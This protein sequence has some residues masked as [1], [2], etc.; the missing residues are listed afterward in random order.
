MPLS[1]EPLLIVGTG[2]LACFFAARLSQAGT[3]V[4]MLGSWPEGLA[5]LKERGVRVIQRDGGET[6]YPVEVYSVSDS[7]P[8][9]DRALVLVKSWQTERAAEQLQ[10]CLGPHGYALTLQN[11][12]GNYEI[13]ATGLG[14]KRTLAGVTT[15]GASLIAPGQVLP[16]GDGP[17]SI[18]Q[19]RGVDKFASIFAQAGFIVEV[20]PDV[21]ALLWRKLV[22][23]A[24]INP[25]T[26]ILGVQNGK[27]SESDDLRILMAEIA[28]EVIH[29]ISAQGIAVK[30]EDPMG[31]IESV[32]HGTASNRSSMLQDLDRGAPTEID[33][34]CGAIVQSGKEH[35][36][37]TPV[38]RT[39]WRLVKSAVEFKSK[40][41]D[42]NR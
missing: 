38:N 27:L 29:V 30:M 6:A 3:S 26:A 10:T 14:E 18:G 33:A 5:S 19:H 1:S 41:N 36:V 20:V 15:S 16:G 11:G 21:R 23:N 2:A 40:D 39:L 31:T 42:G 13:L 22:I 8:I 32:V 24:A 25:L 7:I 37:A 35:G 9:F 28:E 17:I 34:I 12:L 4:S